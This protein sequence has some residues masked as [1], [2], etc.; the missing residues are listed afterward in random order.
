MSIVGDGAYAAATVAAQVDAGTGLDCAGNPF[1]Q[2][3]HPPSIYHA[4]SSSSDESE[5]ET[6]EARRRR[7]EKMKAKIEK[8]TEKLMMKR[9]KE[10]SEKHPFF[11]LHQVPHNYPSYQYPTSQFQLVHLGN[12]L[13]LMGWII[14]SGLMI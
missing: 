5:G 13:S 3:S 14:P 4:N 11:G 2:A 12:L 1:R 8:K 7:K 9:I 6:T 10:E